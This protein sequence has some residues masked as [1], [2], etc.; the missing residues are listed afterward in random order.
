MAQQRAPLV[1]AI[2]QNSIQQKKSGGGWYAFVNKTFP[3]LDELGDFID[4]RIQHCLM[5]SFQSAV[6][7]TSNRPAHFGRCECLVVLPLPGAGE[8]A[9]RYRQAVRHHGDH[10]NT[11]EVAEM[12]TP[13]Q[14]EL[15]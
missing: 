12:D 14:L 3:N 5:R 15:F 10:L 4:A 6:S 13:Q 8:P 2:P 1:P 9:G 11:K 7:A